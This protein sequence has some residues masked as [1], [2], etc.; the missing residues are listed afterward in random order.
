M[1]GKQSIKIFFLILFL[2]I[3]V[4]ISHAQQAAL[5]Q[6]GQNRVQMRKFEWKY[7]DTTHFR[8]MYYDYGKFNAQFL[9]QQAEMDLPQ[10]VFMMGARLPNKI[11]VVVYNSYGDYKQT[12]VGRYNDELNESQNGIVDVNRNTIVVFF[13]GTHDGLRKQ[14]KRGIAK[15]IKDNLLFGYT[16]KEIVKNA[17]SMNVPT[18]FTNGYVQYISEDWDATKNARV[19]SMIG[20]KDKL[21]FKDLVEQDPSLIGQSFFN[22]VGEKYNQTAINNLL[23][24]IRNRTPL[25][26]AINNVFE[27]KDKVLFAEWKAFYALAPDSLLADT[28]GARMYMSVI[29]P[30]AGVVLKQ[31][32]VSPDAGVIAYAEMKDGKYDIKLFT[33]ANGKSTTIIEGGVRNSLELKD[34]NYPIIC[35][36]TDG[37]K[38]AVMYEKDYMQRLKIYDAKNGRIS[39]RIITKNKFDRINGMAF[40]EDDD[41]LVLSCIKKGQSDLYQF[42]IKNARMYQVTK[43]IWDDLAPAFVRRNGKTGIVFMSNRPTTFLE[44]PI[45]ND[46][47]P[48][49]PFHLFYY[50]D[51]DGK[52]LIKCSEGVDVKLD[53]PIQYGNE[54]LAFLAD[55]KGKNQRYIITTTKTEKGKDSSYFLL[56]NPIDYSIMQHA[57]LKMKNC[58][59]DVVDKKGKYYIYKTPIS[60][61]DTFDKFLQSAP[62]NSINNKQKTDVQSPNQDVYFLSEFVNDIDSLEIGK[63]KRDPLAYNP[64]AEIKPKR[65]R[66]KEYIPLFSTD[67]L[68]TSVDNS[69]LFNRYQKLDMGNSD[70]VYPPIGALLRL[71]LM[72]VLEDYKISAG[73]RVPYDFSKTMSYLLK[74]ANYKKRVDWEITFYHTSNLLDKDNSMLDTE[75]VYYSP[76][77]EKAKQAQNYLQGIFTYPIDIATAIKWE[78]GLRHDQL[79]YKAS[80]EYSIG[81]PALSEYWWFNRIEYLY[82]NTVQPIQNIRKGTRFKV[83]SDAF[84]QLK[85]GKGNMLALGLDARHYLG[86]YKNIIL[87]SRFSAAGSFGKNRMLYRIGGIDNEII[88]L[89]AQ[90]PIIDPSITYGYQTTVTNFRGYAPNSR[91]G[92]TYMVVNEEIRIPVM[93]TFTTRTSKS[94]M[95][96]NLQLVGFTDVGSAWT[97]FIDGPTELTYQVKNNFTG[98]VKDVYVPSTLFGYGFGFRT[99]LLGY[100]I[101]ANLGWNGVN[102]KK[103]LSVGMQMDF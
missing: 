98:V 95:L 49:L 90:T 80:T 88:P 70:F 24:Y 9:L 5:E 77:K 83:Y 82:D 36:N 40:M 78:T 14:I 50:D 35:W 85:G 99:T 4:Q 25:S 8:I 47:L 56:S 67:F 81:F 11:D 101:N 100:Y 27:K 102:S 43:D 53:Q 12:N 3:K 28:S 73:V 59:I 89:P 96:R 58:I 68:Q 48:N 13:D 20:K 55:T 21:H 7:Y 52:G 93:N 75:N 22:F 15:I 26:N 60:Y 63:P 39:N 37:K 16:L 97:N 103:R 54:Q 74:F 87:A 44:S 2:V 65:Y 84:L 32:A 61:L 38:L 23:F 92:S 69:L 91:N 51:N 86:I 64:D 42:T 30:K 33:V 45:K 1:K 94:K 62:T 71:S 18:W 29:K 72:D 19:Q 41:K 6:F 46:Q 31:F 66:S 17:M 10:I 34:P 76:I 79:K 57:Y